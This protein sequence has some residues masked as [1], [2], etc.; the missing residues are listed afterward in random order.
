MAVIFVHTLAVGMYVLET[1]KESL[2]KSYGD[3]D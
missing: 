3:G 2:E 1:M